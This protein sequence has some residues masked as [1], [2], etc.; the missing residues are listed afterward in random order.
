MVRPFVYKSGESIKRGDHVTY[1]GEQGT[2]EFVVTNKVG[3]RVLDWYIDQYPDGG[4]MI[5][6]EGFGSVFLTESNFDED[7]V[8]VARGD[9][10]ERDAIQ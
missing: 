2:V 10:S 5:K 4:F 3:D 6:A 8:F 9:A 7:L 1:H